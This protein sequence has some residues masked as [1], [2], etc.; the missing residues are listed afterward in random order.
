MIVLNVGTESFGF[1]RLVRAVDEAAL[2][3][4]EPV[5][6]QIG[7]CAHEPRAMEHARLVPFDELRARLTS[8][9]RVV[10]HA[11]AGTTLL[12]MS[13]GHVPVLL[14]RLAKHGEH[15]DDHQ[16]EFAERL[17]ERGLAL[18]ARDAAEAVELLAKA[19]HRRDPEVSSVP[20]SNA[21]REL[22]DHLFALVGGREVGRRAA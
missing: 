17:A 20:A 13:L 19:P 14:P 8:A 6:A 21:G 4:G 7:S 3:L 16:V 5:F 15:V 9:S 12:A 22:S 10:C 2:G 1:D 18:C 11:G